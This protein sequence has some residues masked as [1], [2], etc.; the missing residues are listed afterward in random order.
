LAELSRHL[1]PSMLAR[2]LAQLESP[3]TTVFITHIKPGEV[4]RVMREIARAGIA[5]QL[6]ALQSGQ[7]MAVGAR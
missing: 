3:D 6:Q 5:H 7:N 2:E 4:E 1:S